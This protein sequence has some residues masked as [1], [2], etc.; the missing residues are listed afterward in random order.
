[1]T[2]KPILR[3]KDGCKPLERS[4]KGEITN[5]VIIPVTVLSNFRI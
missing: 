5:I 4:E 1:M 3:P 2:P